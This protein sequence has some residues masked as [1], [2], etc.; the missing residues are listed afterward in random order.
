MRNEKNVSLVKS[1]LNVSLQLSDDATVLHES[2]MLLI[3]T[4]EQ[5]KQW[6]WFSIN[7][8]SINTR[9][10]AFRMLKHGLR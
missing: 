2:L 10:D 8:R 3:P 9:K 5:E 1:E 4:Y 7:T 6:Q